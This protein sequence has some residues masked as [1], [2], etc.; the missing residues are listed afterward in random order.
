M[1]IDRVYSQLT[2]DLQKKLLQKIVTSE[3]N[4][5]QNTDVAYGLQHAK[6]TYSA[7]SYGWIQGGEKGRFYL[8]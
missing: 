6:T 1:G 3:V 5:P 4:G 2:T 7:Y 8:M